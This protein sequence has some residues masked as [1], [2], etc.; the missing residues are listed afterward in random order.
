MK[1]SYKQKIIDFYHDN[2]RMP[3]YSEIMNL[4]NFKSKNAVFELVKKLCREDFLS[5]DDKGRLIPKKL[6]QYTKILGTIEAGFPSPAEEELCDNISLDDFLIKNKQAAYILQVSGDSM[7]D[8][9]IMP[10]DLVIVDRSLSPQD[11]NIVI[12]EV[13][14]NWTM[15]Y[16][17]KKC[18]KIYLKAANKKYKDIIAEEKLK[19]AA[20]VKAVIRKY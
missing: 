4:L 3:T 2:K 18:G 10:G 15:K 7:K 5:K 16:F 8:A 13:D 11:G 20:V 12:A 6:I 17:K 19:I 1:Q 14:N 9:G